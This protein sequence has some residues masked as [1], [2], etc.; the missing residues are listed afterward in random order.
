MK[1]E[2]KNKWCDDCKRVVVYYWDREKKLWFHRCPVTGR[3]KYKSEV[4]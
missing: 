4:E 3:Y 2:G 1:G